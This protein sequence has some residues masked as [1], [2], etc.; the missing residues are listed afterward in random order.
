MDEGHPVQTTEMAR[1]HYLLEF[2]QYDVCTHMKCPYVPRVPHLH[3]ITAE[4]TLAGRPT[5]AAGS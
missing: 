4:V 3:R 1:F 5:P 2:F